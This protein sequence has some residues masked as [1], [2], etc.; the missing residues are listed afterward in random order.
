MKNWKSWI[1]VTTLSLGL[2]GCGANIAQDSAYHGAGTNGN[3][4]LATD[5]RTGWDRNHTNPD[6]TANMNDLGTRYPG[7]YNKNS[8]Y[9]DR[10][11]SVQTKSNY[12]TKNYGYATYTKRDMNS[13]QASS[14]FV[15]RNVL[16]RA[17]STV[18]TSIPGVEKANVLVTDEDLF[19]GLPGVINKST[20]NKAKLSAWSMSP[21]YYKI[22]VTGDQEVINQVNRLVN[23]S[24]PRNMSLDHL[25]QILSNGNLTDMTGTNVTD[26]GQNITNYNLNQDYPNTNATHRRSNQ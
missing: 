8:I 21:R 9:Q 10:N 17:V 23:Q 3:R 18:V 19:I 25:D 6:A 2:V 20:L 15:D 13:Q 7:A 5:D 22:Y 12:Q 14:F 16:A 11:M 26:N 24:G 1:A 4:S